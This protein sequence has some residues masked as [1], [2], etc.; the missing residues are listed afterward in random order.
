MSNPDFALDANA[1]A[2][3]IDAQL[4]ALHV[5]HHDDPKAHVRV[6]LRWAR[7][8]VARRAYAR[9]AFQVVAGLVFAGPASLVQRYTGLVAPAFDARK[10]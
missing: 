4:S 7:E 2:A 10:E 3:E 5:A 6:H 1:S 8:H 9:A